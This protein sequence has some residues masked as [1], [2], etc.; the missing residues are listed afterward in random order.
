ML[1]EEPST[2][3]PTYPEW[4]SMKN[5][6]LSS[7][8][9]GYIAFQIFAGELTRRYGAKWLFTSSTFLGSLSCLLLPLFASLF[10]SGGVIFCR[11]LQGLGQSFLWPCAHSLLSKWTPVGDRAKTVA[12]TYSGTYRDI[13]NTYSK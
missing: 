1:S 10:G 7:F 13:L 3:I 9:W 8:F 12:F 4:S 2:G 5:V 11:V 6:M